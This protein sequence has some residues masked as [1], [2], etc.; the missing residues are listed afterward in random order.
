[1][2]LR[3]TGLLSVQ[4]RL[5][6]RLRAGEKEARPELDEGPCCV[7]G[8]ITRSSL[9]ALAK[10]VEE[11]KSRVNALLWG[12]SGAVLLDVLLRLVGVGG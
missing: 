5:R 11:V 6:Q 7:Y 8:L 1:M 2:E 3:D 9:D 4:E 10:H 12:V